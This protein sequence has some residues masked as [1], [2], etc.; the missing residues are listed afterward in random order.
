MK[1]QIKNATNVFDTRF[2]VC[3]MCHQSIRHRMHS[4]TI[5]VPIPDGTLPQAIAV[6]QTAAGY[7][8]LLTSP[9]TQPDS[10]TR[11]VAAALQHGLLGAVE[12]ARS[13]LGGTT[14]LI[15]AAGS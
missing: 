12:Q 10:G 6:L 13:K 8:A 1:Q 9:A 14:S 7:I 15:A 4:L 11:A 3:N 2:A 5:D